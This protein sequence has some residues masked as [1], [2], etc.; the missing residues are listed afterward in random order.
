VTKLVLLLQAIFLL[1]HAIL[2][3]A[4]T[5]D[6]HRVHHCFA[7]CDTTSTLR[8]SSA[9]RLVFKIVRELANGGYA[10]ALPTN[11]QDNRLFLSVPETRRENLGLS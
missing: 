10:I 8:G 6:T 7:G 5:S 11:I 4:E 2:S 1:T 9:V 3:N